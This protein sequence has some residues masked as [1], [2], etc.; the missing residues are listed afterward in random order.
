MQWLDEVRI[1]TDK[2]EKDGV[3][4]GAIGVIIMSEIRAETFEVVFSDK[5][6][7]DYAMKENLNIQFVYP[8]YSLPKG[9]VVNSRKRR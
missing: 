5:D 1:T 4:K 9:S 6:G 2:Y 7:Y 8:N 3:K